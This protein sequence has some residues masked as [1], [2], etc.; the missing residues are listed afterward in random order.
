MTVERK[1]DFKLRRFPPVQIFLY[2]ML[3]TLLMIVGMFP[4]AMAPQ[5]GRWLGRFVKLLDG[6]HR[7]VA[8]NNLEKSRGVC[9]SDAIPEFVDRVYDHLG[10]LA[11]EMMMIPKLIDRIDEVVR[12]E[13]F[14]IVEE[15]RRR[16]RG[17]ITVIGHL[18][19]WELIGLAVCH[20][21][22]PLH[23]L[24]RPIENPWIDRYLTGFRTQTGQRIIPKYH[25]LGEM[26]RV[27]QKNEI[28]IIQ[29]DQDARSHGVYA[30]FFGR[31]AST[32]RSPA[33]LSLKYGTPIVVANIYREGGQHCCV[34]SDPILPETFKDL[35]DPVRA[36]TQAYTAKFEACVRQ[37]PDQWFWIHGRWKTAER[38][39]EAVLA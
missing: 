28:L 37:H 18:G 15:V 30:D 34:L 19:N 13:R 14:H 7:R 24:A 35:P 11:V 20:A 4:Y 17:M 12:L 38:K 1:R 36:L 21:G 25:A 3:R 27:L 31:P 26:I 16:G 32:H 10:M 9:P 29:V 2:G 39:P 22:H 8:I 5:V 23:S 6:R 33:L